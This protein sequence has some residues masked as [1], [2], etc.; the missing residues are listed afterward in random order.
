MN[1]A[2]IV[3]DHAA[4]SATIVGGGVGSECQVILFRRCAETVEHDSG[5]NARDAA[6][7]INFQNARHVFGKIQNDGD[8]AALSG[9]GRA[10][11]ATKK[12][13][14]KLA[15]ECH[16]CDNVISI[17]GENYADWNLTVI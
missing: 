11:A 5:L 6:D 8:I 14:A 3:A 4:E 9:E 7:G 16:G 2:G 13:R 1:A 17:A 12:R 10:S 15:A